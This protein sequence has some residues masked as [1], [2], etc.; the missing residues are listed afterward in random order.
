M[1]AGDT[2]AVLADHAELF[3]EG[4]AFERDVTEINR[5]AEQRSRTLSASLGI[6]RRQAGV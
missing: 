6:R 5:A 4:E 2:L 3:I 1:T